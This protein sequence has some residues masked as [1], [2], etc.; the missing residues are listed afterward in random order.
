MQMR[1]YIMPKMRKR[2]PTY[3][4]PSLRCVLSEPLVGFE[5]T[6]PRL[7]IRWVSLLHRAATT[8]YP[9]C[10]QALGDSE[11]ACRVGLTRVQK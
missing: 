2:K 11:G 1:N 4:L 9:C 3:K 6:T 10:G 7:Q 8:K 5:P